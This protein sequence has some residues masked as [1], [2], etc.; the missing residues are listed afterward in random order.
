MKPSLFHFSGNKCIHP[1]LFYYLL[2]KQTL[3][4]FK[5]RKRHSKSVVLNRSVAA[6]MGA[7]K[8][9]QG[10]CLVLNSGLY[11]L[12]SCS[13]GCREIISF[14]KKGAANQRRLRTTAPN[15][16]HALDDW[17]YWI[18]S[19]DVMLTIVNAWTSDRQ[20]RAGIRAQPGHQHLNEPFVFRE[21]CAAG[22]TAHL[23]TDVSLL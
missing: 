13:K 23:F 4:L 1:P 11:L 3:R 18:R 15:D 7:L 21:K 22:S 8:M 9:L 2:L 14:P 10:C 16:A 12:I 20:I 19:Y 5:L 6:P 17:P